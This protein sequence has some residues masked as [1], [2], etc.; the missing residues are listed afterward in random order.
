MRAE[1]EGT[2][3]DL[4]TPSRTWSIKEIRILILPCIKFSTLKYRQKWQIF[5]CI[6]SD[7]KIVG[8]YLIECNHTWWRRYETPLFGVLCSVGISLILN[9]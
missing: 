4:H 6:R 9:Y 2:V 3:A 7:C 1:K 5:V 8:S